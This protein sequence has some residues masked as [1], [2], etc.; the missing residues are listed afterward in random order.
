MENGEVK[1]QAAR[2]KTS[3]SRGKEAPGPRGQPIPE[4]NYLKLY[5]SYSVILHA[6]GGSLSDCEGNFQK[7]PRR[8]SPYKR[9][10][11]VPGVYKRPV[12]GATGGIDLNCQ[13]SRKIGPHRA[14]FGLGFSKPAFSHTEMA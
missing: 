13:M 7:T 9:L 2:N 8:V 12:G 6:T 11:M 14:R 1:S 3:A 4:A 10:I 5:W